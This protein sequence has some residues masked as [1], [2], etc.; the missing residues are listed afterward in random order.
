MNENQEHIDHIAREKLFHLEVE[1]PKVVWSRIENDLYS[2]KRKMSP[3]FYRIAAALIIALGITG[4]VVKYG[5]RQHP[6]NSEAHASLL[7]NI[8]TTPP[9]ASKAIINPKTTG[10]QTEIAVVNEVSNQ[11]KTT[12]TG[13]VSKVPEQVEEHFTAPSMSSSE[14]AEENANPETPVSSANEFAEISKPESSSGNIIAPD[15]GNN[16]IRITNTIT[17]YSQT[18]PQSSKNVDIIA[19]FSQPEDAGTTSGGSNMEWVVSANAGPQYTDQFMN[20]AN[21]SA[22]SNI[23]SDG[24]F[25][26]AGGLQVEMKPASRFSFGTG[27]SYSRMGQENGAYVY[28]RGEKS[29]AYGSN[30]QGGSQSF[31]NSNG[32]P[33]VLNTNGSRVNSSKKPVVNTDNTTAPNSPSND[34]LAGTISQDATFVSYFGFVEVPLLVKYR[35]IDRKKLNVTFSGGLWTNFLVGNSTNLLIGKQTA[36]AETVNVHTV[37][38]SS[39]LG[40]GFEYPFAS[41]L[42]ISVEPTFRYYLNSIY[43]NDS[44]N[45]RPYSFGIMTGVSYSF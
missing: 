3:F 7:K 17:D 25:A 45:V 1:P 2:G 28:N 9:A 23:K 24:V 13:K 37:N 38:Y 4:L 34:A 11:N 20:A 35:L 12:V 42:S 44:Y 16:Q 6:S 41:S 40:L 14:A 33:L 18:V 19:A 36:P 32:D 27:I 29:Y 10:N 26:Y 15:S 39:S 31:D 30:P 21:T 22:N 43:N 5:P 8:T